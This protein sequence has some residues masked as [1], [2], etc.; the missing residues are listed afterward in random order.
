MADPVLHY[1]IGA[2]AVLAFAGF[3]YGVVVGIVRRRQVLLWVNPAMAML[4]GVGLPFANRNFS[5]GP[6]TPGMVLDGIAWVWLVIATLFGIAALVR[7]DAPP[8]Y[9][10]AWL[11]TALMA[12]VMLAWNRH[13]LADMLGVLA[14]VSTIWSVADV[15]RFSGSSTSVR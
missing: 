9:Y 6:R 4:I 2:C 11:A 15:I 7:R 13:P 8:R 1:A 5:S 12:G 3:V 10:P 14:M